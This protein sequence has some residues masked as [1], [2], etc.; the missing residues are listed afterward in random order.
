MIAR[1]DGALARGSGRVL[2][3]LPAGTSTGFPR[4]ALRDGAAYVVWTESR[5]GQ[6]TIAGARVTA[7]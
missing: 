2:R 3:E 4:M 6:P 5:D 7:R 1:W